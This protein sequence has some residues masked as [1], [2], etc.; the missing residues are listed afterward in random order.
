MKWMD[1]NKDSP[2]S[3]EKLKRI[4]D[5][6]FEEQDKWVAV[7]KDIRDHISPYLGFFDGDQPNQGNR[8]DSCMINTNALIASNTFAAGMHNGITSPTRPWVRIT[9]RDKDSAEIEGVR[10]WCDAV[11]QRILDVCSH[12]N[13]YHEMHKFYKELGVFGTAVMMIV[14]DFDTVVRCRTLTCGQY[15]IGTDHADRVKRFAMKFKMQVSEIIDRFGVENVPPTIRTLYENKRYNTFYDVYHLIVTNSDV[16]KEKVDKWSKPFSSFYWCEGL[17]E[18]EYLDIG[19]YD[20]FPAM[21]ARW[22]TVGSNIYGYGPG[23][24]ALGDAK[25]VQVVD[26]DIHIAV[27]KGIDPPIAAPAD[28]MMAGGVNT[29]HNGIT[30]Y[31]REMGDSAI[32]PLS[33][34]QLDLADAVTLLQRKEDI[35]NKHFFVDLFRMLENVS[36]AGVTK[37]EIIQRVNEKMSLIGPA[38]DNIQNTLADIVDRLFGIMSRS[39][40]LPEPDDSIKE[41]ISGQITKTEFVSTMAQ[42]QKAT[43]ITSLQRLAEYVGQVA[44]FAPSVLD[45][46]D[47]DESVDKMSDMLGTAPSIVVSDDKV[48]KK[49]EQEQQQQQIQQA[50]MY[51]QQ[52]AQGAKTLSDTQVGNGSALDA[53]MPGL[54]AG[55]MQQ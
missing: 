20:E 50:A 25:S 40:V 31:Q 4:Y 47:A 32:R 14:G 13:F 23:H 9:L 46:F 3:K 16:N 34:V 8:K 44:Q 54:G 21:C 2:I 18:N 51:A 28:V 1:G 12:S 27:K 7:W 36:S 10:W 55:G 19:G 15:A 43:G 26:E 52:A 17:E 11:T 42:A 6:L 38:L 5:G 30:Y 45:K 22:D 33:Q 49:R 48:Q 53:L 41:I 35:L 37:E 39:N 29:E 24:Y